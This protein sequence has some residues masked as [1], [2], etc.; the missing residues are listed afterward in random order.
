MYNDQ[1]AWVRSIN[2]SY[3]QHG[4]NEG[5]DGSEQAAPT[6][7]AL[8]FSSASRMAFFCR[9]WNHCMHNDSTAQLPGHTYTYVRQTIEKKHI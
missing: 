3:M 7:P 2:Q 5:V 8:I 9:V 6:S 4:D 1:F